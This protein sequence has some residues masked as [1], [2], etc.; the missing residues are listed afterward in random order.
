MGTAVMHFAVKSQVP[1]LL[2]K[3]AVSRAS[4]PEANFRF[5]VFVDGSP[6]S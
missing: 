2:V 3:E 5:A 4:K 1:V 6:L